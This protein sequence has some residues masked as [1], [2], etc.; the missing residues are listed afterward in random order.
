MC[1][2]HPH[3]PAKPHDVL[4]Q[5]LKCLDGL[6]GRQQP[7]DLIDRLGDSKGIDRHMPEQKICG[8]QPPWVGAKSAS[9]V[10]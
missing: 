4:L 9:A 8:E 6:H 7:R 5:V 3:G 1:D 10:A 2:E